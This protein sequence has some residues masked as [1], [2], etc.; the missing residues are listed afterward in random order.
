MKNLRKTAALLATLISTTLIIGLM[1]CDFLAVAAEDWLSAPYGYV[2]DND[3][4]G[5][6]GATVKVYNGSSQVQSTATTSSTGYFSLDSKVDSTGGTYTVKVTAP[7]TS[8][9][10]YDDVTVIVPDDGYLYNIGAIKPKTGI[11]SVSGSIINVREL[12]KSTSYTKPTA[13]TVELRKF[14][15]TVATATAT[16]SSDLSYTI[17]GVEPGSYFVTFK[18]ASVDSIAWVGIPI[19]VEVSGGNITNLG[20]FVYNDNL[21][22]G[23]ILLVLSWENRDYDIDTHAYAGTVGSAIR[24][25][26]SG[27]TTPAVAKWERDI[28]AKTGDVGALPDG[29]NVIASGAYP[30]ETTVVESLASGTELRFFA[31]AFLANTSVTG[32]DDGTGSVQPSGV[33]LYAMSDAV[34]FGTWFSPLNSFETA[35]GMVQIIGNGDGTMTLSTFGGNTPRALGPVFGNGAIVTEMK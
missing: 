24:V 6:A 33:K 32:L 11:Y 26:T 29:S 19:S 25:T 30:V 5:L 3:G 14:G 4:V 13:G 9:L 7:T 21:T 18:K 15:E 12:E 16:V 23:S 1:G 10:V 28:V 22:A 35:I 34:H 8:Y 20:T 31:K 17:N 2:Y 27:I